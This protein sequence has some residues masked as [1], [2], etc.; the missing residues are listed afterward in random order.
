MDRQGQSYASETGPF[1]GEPFFDDSLPLRWMVASMSDEQIQH[2]GRGGHDNKKIYA[3]FKAVSEHEGQR[4]VIL[5]QS[6]KGW[7][8]G[9]NFEGRNATH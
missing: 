9:T 6:V 5:A 7:T 4:T 1:L 2:L 8:L 3:A